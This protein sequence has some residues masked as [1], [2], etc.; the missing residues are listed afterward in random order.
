MI[1]QARFSLLNFHNILKISIVVSLSG[2]MH[3]RL[4]FD[5]RFLFLIKDHN[6]LWTIILY[7]L[8]ACTLY[9]IRHFI[10]IDTRSIFQKQKK[11]KKKVESINNVSFLLFI[12]HAE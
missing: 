6:I 9:F 4:G 11:K 12:S 8:L 1:P 3:V 10:I 7:L 2:L 5:D